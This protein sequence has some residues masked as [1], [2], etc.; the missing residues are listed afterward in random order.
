ME[1]N[2]TSKA[3]SGLLVSWK[4]MAND[5]L[6]I[7]R[8]SGNRGCKGTEEVD[9]RMIGTQPPGKALRLKFWKQCDVHK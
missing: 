6:A 8:F 2:A 4:D 9:V 5:V 3:S 1:R 7:G